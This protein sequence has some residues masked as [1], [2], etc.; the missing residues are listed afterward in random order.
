MS[1][2]RRFGGGGRRLNIRHQIGGG[3]EMM[4]AEKMA[5][6]LAA[7]SFGL[8]LYETVLPLFHQFVTDPSGGGMRAECSVWCRSW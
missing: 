2:K 8:G 1:Y 6:G 3:G 5:A 7:F 4:D